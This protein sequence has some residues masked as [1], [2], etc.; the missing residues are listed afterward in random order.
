MTDLAERLRA[1]TDDQ[2]RRLANLASDHD[3]GG[4][5]SHVLTAFV[6]L[7]DAAPDADELRSFLADRLPPPAVP[8]AFVVVEEMPRTAA[9]K[10]DRRAIHRVDGSALTSRAKPGSNVEAR[11]ATEE[12]LLGVWAEVLGIGADLIAVD[13]DFFEMG[14]DS[15]LSIR[16]ISR[17]ARAGVRITPESFFEGP[18]VAQLAARADADAS[19][20]SPPDAPSEPGSTREIDPATVFGT[21]L[22]R[23]RSGG[24]AA[25]LVA[26]PGVFGNLWIFPDLARE[27][28]SG[29]PFYGLQSRGLDGARPPLETIEQIAEEF[30]EL[31]EPLATS[32]VHLFGV[33]WGSAVVVEMAARL[34]ALGVPPKSV[35]LLNPGMLLRTDPAPRPNAR[36]VFL[37]DRLELYWGEF[38]EADWA[39]RGRLVVD[40]A[41][42]AVRTVAKGLEASVELELLQERVIAAN[43]RAIERYRPP[44]VD[45]ARARLFLTEREHTDRPDHRLEWSELIHPRP[46][47][48][49]VL[50]VDAGDVVLH[51]APE[52]ASALDDWL[53]V[54]ESAGP[55]AS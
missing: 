17:A 25:P 20:P 32:G 43:R 42:T 6:T 5:A 13:D 7:A 2:R 38:R 26:V 39:D 49:Q 28:R 16:V 48:V 35:S 30:V 19:A 44:Q 3:E 29:R 18:T 21:P 1:L 55:R 12:V 50:G 24:D 10:L 27:L 33:C 15:L 34:T 45:V 23:I 9:G 31:V 47:V 53:D 51:H 40:K 22:V 46:D 36:L 37:R 8:G 11:S 41:R 52:L 54:V 14:G 4:G